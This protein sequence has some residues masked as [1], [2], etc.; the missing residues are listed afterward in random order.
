MQMNLS[1]AR[2][3]LAA[4]ILFGLNL[5]CEDDIEDNSG[6]LQAHVQGV[7]WKAANATASI[8]EDGRLIIIGVDDTQRMVLRAANFNPGFYSFS[9]TLQNS[10]SFET[11]SGSLSAATRPFQSTGAVTI[12]AL[13]SQKATVTGNFQFIA[14]DNFN[15]ENFFVREGLFY[16]IPIVSFNPD[17]LNP[18]DPDPPAD[19]DGGDGNPDDP[20]PFQNHFFARINGNPFPSQSIS[21]S[22]TN[23]QICITNAVPPNMQPAMTLCFAENVS[24]GVLTLG[25]NGT[26]AAFYTPGGIDLNA[27][28][29]SIIIDSHDTAGREVRGRFSFNINQQGN[30]IEVTQG[31]FRVR[32]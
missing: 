17:L 2:I 7:F 22:V 21:T 27:D 15:G 25:I 1:K 32:Y 24:P 26:S 9:S 20:G 10:A 4:L 18:I 13:N 19:D 31:E 11:F 12:T 14:I 29:G 5:S 3:F 28:A 16:E 8:L 6:A 23:G 30:P